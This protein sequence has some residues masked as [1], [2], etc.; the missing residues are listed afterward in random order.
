MVSLINFT[1]SSVQPAFTPCLTVMPVKY[2]FV[3]TTNSK[4]TVPS[5]DFSTANFGYS[6]F[7]GFE[8]NKTKNNVVY[9]D[10]QQMYDLVSQSTSKFTKE[11]L[12]TL[13]ALQE[14]FSRLKFIQESRGTG[15]IKFIQSFLYLGDYEDEK[16]NFIP[17]L[18]I[19]SGN[20]L[21]I[22]NNK[23]RP[24]SIDGVYYLS[25]NKE[26]DLT[27]PP[28]TSHIK[29]LGYKFPGTLLIVKIYL[30]EN[31]LKKK[32]EENGRNNH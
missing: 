2:P 8:E 15:T 27:M 23:Y 17:N 6:I 19:Y 10:M 1:A 14:G 5:T 22:C 7:E 13:Y 4:T 20:T 9:S 12:F 29:Q 24:F 25:L 28:E 21:L 26:K 11:N 16:K 31:H 18:L 3:S 32:M 30:N